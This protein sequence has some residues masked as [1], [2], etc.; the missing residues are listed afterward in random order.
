MPGGYVSILFL[1]D[2]QKIYNIDLGPNMG[3]AY[4][5]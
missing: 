3:H 5:T 1:D 2:I 4:A